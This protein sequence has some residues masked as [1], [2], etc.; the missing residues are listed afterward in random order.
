MTPPGYVA[1]LLGQYQSVGDLDGIESMLVRLDFKW[2]FP[3]FEQMSG[4]LNWILKQAGVTPWPE[5]RDIVFYHP[6]E[7]IWYIAWL[8]GAPWWQVIVAALVGFF[9]STVGIA[10]AAVFLGALLYRIIPGGI[11]EPLEEFFNMLPP[12]LGIATMGFLVLAVP[13]LVERVAPSKEGG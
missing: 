1:E 7:A 9:T 12:L 10:L 6:S 8:K 11:R 2:R 4:A 5:Y 3:L 13:N